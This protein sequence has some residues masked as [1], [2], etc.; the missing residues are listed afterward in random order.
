[1]RKW[2]LVW[3]AILL[4]MILGLIWM[5]IRLKPM[6]QERLI[7]AIKEQYSRDV[8]LKDLNISLLPG[9][10][11]VGEGLVL[12][13]QDRPGLPPMVTVKKLTVQASLRGVLSEPLQV[14]RLI[15]EGLQINVP[16]KQHEPD[17]DKEMKRRPPRFVIG[18]VIADGTLLQILPR[19][20][21]KEP[22]TFD[23]SRLTLHSA[24]TTQPMRFHATLTNPKPPGNVFSTGEFGPWND[25][26]PSFTPVSGDYTFKNADLSV[27]KGIAG[28]LA[29]EGKYGGTLGRIEVD[30]TTDTPDFAVESGGNP[31]NL[32]TQFHAIVDGTDGD[33]YLEPL[34]AQF[35]RSSLIAH[36]GIYGKPG[37]KGKTVSLDVTVFDSRIEDLLRLAVK[38]KKPLMTGAVAFKTKFELPPGDRNV[39][40]KL[41]LYGGFGVGAARFTS[42]NI[43]KK[44]N[45]LSQRARGKVGD[46]AED[47]SVVSNLRGQF[48]LNN[49]A[50]RFSRLTFDVPGAAVE[51]QGG[52]RLSSEELNFDGTL[53]TQAKIS[54]MTTGV[55]SFFLKLAD[56]LFK[57]KNAGA[58]V[59]IKISGTR[60]E[61]KF[62]VQVGRIFSR[63]K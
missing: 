10:S 51:L 50:I 43:Q 47:E 28:I 6:L 30:G 34:K 33:T 38:G 40:E 1:M 14:E 4:A 17:E 23:I 53:R 16:P 2:L 3:A 42:F 15:L 29:S 20:E 56:P 7:I 8:E 41:K 60:K 49:G 55:K 61:P 44:V 5:S 27:F 31:V 59:P 21:G 13:Q 32:K 26:E 39:I 62:G 25:E 54:Q 45:N 37:V 52:Y 57:T 58:V 19:K 9:F 48:I 46:E 24:G 36:G 63:K 12:H 35:G 22:L 11:A 18:E